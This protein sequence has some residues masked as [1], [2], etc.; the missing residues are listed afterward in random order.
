M[1]APVPHVDEALIARLRADLAAADFT[2]I[3]TSEVLGPLAAAALGREQPLPARRVAGASDAPAATLIRL[4]TLGDPVDVAEVERAL[5]TL[6][7]H[8]AIELGLV[9]EEGDG[10]VARCDVRPYASDDRHWWVASDLAE[11]A[12]GT[13]VREDHVLGIGG[14][15]TTL[16]QWTIRRPVRTALD[17]GTGCGV[18]ALHLGHH[19]DEIVV[20]DLS[21]RALAYA[22]FNAALNECAWDVRSGSMLEPVAG[23]RFDLIVSNPPFVITP[24][25]GDV[26]LF[27][28]RDGGAAGDA[29]VAGLVRTVGEHLVPGGVAQFLGNWEVPSGSTW[30][31]RVGA[32]LEGTG[33]DAWVVQREV[34]DPAE[35]A[36][37]WSR[38]GGHHAGTAD[39]DA[40]YAAW[41]D[42]FASRDVESIGF[43][44]ITLHRP[45]TDRTPFVDLM[46][47]RG[48]VP[49]AMGDVAQVGLEARVWLAEHSDDEVLDIAWH[50]TPDVTEERHT[51]PGSSD[52]S[53][54]VA[55]QG[56]GLGRVIR[57]TTVTAAYLSVADGGLTPRQA[58]GAIAGILDLDTAETERE[59]VA[60]VRDAAKDGL[61]VARTD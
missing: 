7:L 11:V 1:T 4:F 40:M 39:F 26:P 25:S 37:T 28:Y 41:L 2:V 61:L 45:E 46:D 8:G 51:L 6:R 56:G 53:V 35:Y 36:E 29:V 54:I 58:V 17:L 60:F 49:P 23:Q 13:P 30:T 42:D 47:E 57:L 27:E 48:P 21:E 9:S 31:E 14:A 22:R 3:G 19:A 10:V 38:D 20:T 18:Q 12:T 52:P 32:W 50:A 55:R 44:V 34:Q 59:V 43:G 15:S 5:P 16:A 24:R 33:L